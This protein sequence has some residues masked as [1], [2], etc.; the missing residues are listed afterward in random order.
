MPVAAPASVPETPPLPDEPAA[1]RQARIA[2]QEAALR[3]ESHDTAGALERLREALAADAAFEPAYSLRATI[4]AASGRDRAAEDDFK[5][6]LKLDPRDADAIHNF[7][8]H[9]CLHRRY[10]DA[11]TLFRRALALDR[12]D[13]NARTLLAQGMCLY[14]AGQWKPAEDAL[15]RAYELEP[16]SPIV[17][18]NLAELLMRRGEYERARYLI[19][20]VN[21]NPDCVN[22][23]T[24]WLAV[25]I[26]YRAGNRAGA[27]RIGS[28]LAVRY[29][30]SPE[31]DL[32][33]RQ[34]FSD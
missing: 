30:H 25:R 27:A 14:R 10:A 22:S 3:H 1:T 32:F 11:E 17:S 9:L 16:G 5:A 19:R 12:P 20:R 21:A 31:A 28:D 13:S 26:E 24:L 15:E 4:E 2:T 23:Q 7:G 29:P 34:R 6:A 18:V 8:W 33:R